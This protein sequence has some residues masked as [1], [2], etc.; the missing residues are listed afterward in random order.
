LLINTIDLEYE[1]IRVLRSGAG[2]DEFLCKGLQTGGDGYFLVVCLK[3]TALIR[4]AMPIYTALRGSASFDDYVTCFAQRGCAY[5]VFRYRELPL[6]GTELEA[7]RFSLKE[8]LEIARNLLKKITILQ[9]PAYLQYEVLKPGNVQV[10]ESLDVY[11]RYDLEEFEKSFDLPERR[12]QLTLQKLLRL[13]FA[14]EMTDMSSQELLDFVN[15]LK[16]ESFHDY[17]EV[18]KAFD[19][20][21]RS[22]TRLL[23]SGG[24]SPR[25]RPFRVWYRIRSL[26]KYI[27][28]TLAVIV[29]LLLLGYLLY[30]ILYPA[31]KAPFSQM[32]ITKIGTLD[33]K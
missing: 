8:R 18:Y 11:F 24:L 3:D 2:M 20:V 21:Y 17:L 22:L 28:P 7:G 14:R 1:V 15:G 6:L 32:P 25:S 27:R 19:K 23:N 26:A 9:M 10:S 29:L 4:R 33:I 13:L 31:Q 16:T 5:L 12:Y 30:T